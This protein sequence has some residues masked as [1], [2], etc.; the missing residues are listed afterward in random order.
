MLA[1]LH[2]ARD[3]GNHPV[4]THRQPLYPRYSCRPLCPVDAPEFI[5]PILQVRVQVVSNTL[6]SQ[7]VPSQRTANIE[8][9][10]DIVWC[11][12]KVSF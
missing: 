11:T 4:F 1:L 5:Q 6:Q 10:F 12:L 2:E 3:P 7:P 9:L 8:S